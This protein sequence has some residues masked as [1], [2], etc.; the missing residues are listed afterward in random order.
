MVIYS[1]II[2]K[3]ENMIICYVYM[4]ACM[5]MLIHYYVG[6]IFRHHYVNIN[7]NIFIHKVYYRIGTYI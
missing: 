3:I 5:H 1:D 2:K 7:N 6:I 4:Y